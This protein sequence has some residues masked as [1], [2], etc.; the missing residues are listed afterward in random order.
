MTSIAERYFTLRKRL[1]EW[2]RTQPLLNKLAL[3]FVVAALTGVLA[4][5]RFYLPGT[6][7]PVTGQTFAVLISGVA[8]G[9][10]WGGVSQLLYI[11][12]GIAGVPWFA[13]LNGGVAALFGPT[14]GYL[15]GF[16]VASLFV[17][18]Y[19]DTHPKARNFFPAVVVMLAASAIIYA[20]GLANLWLWFSLINKQSISFVRLLQVGM[21]P[22][23]PGDLFKIALAAFT[24]KALTPKEL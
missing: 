9:A 23:I 8:L 12:L 3:S 18:R 1:F 11:V 5:L 14:G 13:G 22:F 19:I 4:Q 15:V 17:G 21:L 7:V 2:P 6:P 20:T 24:I 10:W 16:V